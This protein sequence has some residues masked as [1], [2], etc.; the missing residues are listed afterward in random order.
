[1]M[2][3][4]I[5]M[6]DEIELIFPK[7]PEIEKKKDYAPPLMEGCSSPKEKEEDKTDETG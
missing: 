5:K 3:G 1:M 2:E 6:N 4:E 7:G